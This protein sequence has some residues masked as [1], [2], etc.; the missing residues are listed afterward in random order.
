VSGPVSAGPGGAP[1]APGDKAPATESRAAAILEAAIVVALGL[2]A[3]W[4][5]GVQTTQGA[6]LGLPPAF[7]PTV[8]AI[9]IIAVA[10]LGLAARLWRPEP[11][12]PEQAL[13][14][15]PAAL[16]LGVVT[17][18]GLV[19]QLVGPFA[20]GL[21]TVA[22]GLVLLGE[23]RPL[24]LVGSMAAAAIVLGAVLQVWR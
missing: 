7:L 24:V 9:A 5:I 22:L 14:T 18:G 2:G 21:V 16:L 20:S 11:L 17:A 3:I 15:W 8:C 19:L 10:V 4:L 13:P 6:V 1:S 12:L 23:R